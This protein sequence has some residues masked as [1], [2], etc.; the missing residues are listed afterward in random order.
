MTEF[1]MNSAIS[2]TTTF[3]LF[4]V[5]YRWLPTLFPEIDLNDTQFNG[6]KQF[7]EHAQQ[8][9]DAV[10]NAIIARCIIQ[11]HQANHRRCEEPNLAEGDLVYLS[12]AD[13]N[14]PKGRAHKLLPKFIG[15][16]PIVT[17]QPEVST[18]MLKLLPE[19]VNRWIHPMF[20]VSKL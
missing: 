20:H 14:L 12:T 8:T 5:N 16:Y 6:V 1:V 9:V 17:A 11:T 2:T 15:L 7:I 3:A 4:E 18:Y 19:L 10:H 13:L